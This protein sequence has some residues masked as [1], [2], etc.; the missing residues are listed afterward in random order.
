MVTEELGAGPPQTKKMDQ[1]ALRICC[2]CHFDVSSPSRVS[3]ILSILVM[4]V[5]QSYCCHPSYGFDVI[6]LQWD[7]GLLRVEKKC[8]FCAERAHRGSYEYEY[9]YECCTIPV[10]VHTSITVYSE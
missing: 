10:H 8:H 9:E 5:L 7:D 1:H 2:A 3:T 4:F 6:Q